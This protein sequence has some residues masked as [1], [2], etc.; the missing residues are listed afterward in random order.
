MEVFFQQNFLSLDLGLAVGQDHVFDLLQDQIVLEEFPASGISCFDEVREDLKL[1]LMNL[2][3]END[4]AL[5][6]NKSGEKLKREVFAGLDDLEEV[7]QEV[8]I[9]EVQPVTLPGWGRLAPVV[10]SVRVDGLPPLDEVVSI[11]DQ[12]FGYY[13]ILIEIYWKPT[14]RLQYIFLCVFNFKTWPL[15]QLQW[16]IIL[17]LKIVLKVKMEF[18]VILMKKFS[19]GHD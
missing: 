14:R 12:I 2:L 19:P 7:F 6:Q 4:P 15:Q 5:D 18:R 13:Q 9:A 3:F 16:Q 11:L 10:A 1:A 8:L 17:F